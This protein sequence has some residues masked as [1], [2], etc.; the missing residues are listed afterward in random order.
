MSSRTPSRVVVLKGGPSAEREVSLVSGS[1][2]AGALR[3]AGYDAIEIDAGADPG[4]GAGRCA[5]RR[6]LQ[7]AARPLGRGWLCPGACSN[8]CASPTRIRAF[9]RLRWPWTSRVP[10]RSTPITACP[11][12]R[13]APCP[14]PRSRPDT[15]SSRLMSSSPATRGRPSASTSCPPAPMARPAS[16]QTRPTCCLSRRFVPGRELTTAVLG[17][18]PL[19]VTDIVATAGWYDYHAKYADGGSRHVVPAEVPRAIHDACMAHAVTAH[20]ALRLPRPQPHRF[21]LGRGAWAGRAGAARDQHPARHDADL[22]RARAGEPCRH[23]VRAAL[24]VAGG[25]RV[26]RP[27][28]GAPAAPDLADG[29]PPAPEAK[30]ARGPGPSRLAYRLARIWKEGLGSAR[31]AAGAGDLPRAGRRAHRHQPGR[32][33]LG[34]GPAPGGRRGA[35][36]PPGIR[37]A[38][39]SRHRRLRAARARHRRSRPAASGRIVA[40]ARC[41]CHPGPDRPARPGAQRRREARLGRHA[42]HRHRRADRRGAVA[43]GE[44][45]RGQ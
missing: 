7:R 9:W 11:R 2:C 28:T 8:G 13:A 36:V 1:E 23:L 24:R 31:P 22:A 14:G 10:R 30:A 25:G 16:G 3:R 33:R 39:L 44:R 38:R 45:W 6:R 32:R 4:V 40:D 34:R 42:A 21:P 15:R 20:R 17:E 12:P 29:A 19:A 18:Q 35:F 26:M 43:P 27:L 41:R 5:P 37:R